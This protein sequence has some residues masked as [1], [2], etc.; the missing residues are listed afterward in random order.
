MRERKRKGIRCHCVKSVRIWS[1]YGPYLPAFGLNTD[2]KNSEYEHFLRSV[3]NSNINA[4][5]TSFGRTEVESSS[6]SHVFCRKAVLKTCG[7]LS[8]KRAGFT[9]IGLCLGCFH[10]NFPKN[11]RTEFLQRS[12]WF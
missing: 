11:F 12:S 4:W 5:K 8:G 6:C 3:E 10:V 7:K 9:K 1:Y 2:Q